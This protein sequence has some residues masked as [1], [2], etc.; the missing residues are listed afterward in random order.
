M[1]G[2]WKTY[3]HECINSNIIAIVL[4][5]G[6]TPIFSHI[7]GHLKHFRFR[8]GL[9]SFI[10]IRRV[11]QPEKKSREITVFTSRFSYFN[12]ILIHERYLKI[13]YHNTR[14]VFH[15]DS[16]FLFQFGVIFTLFFKLW[17]CR[18]S[19]RANKTNEI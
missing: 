13:D 1:D 16:H 14:Y 8:H 5:T 7:F 15:P 11:S 12:E 2:S 19:K 4:R 17:S 9:L 6:T 10:L 3:Q 18:L